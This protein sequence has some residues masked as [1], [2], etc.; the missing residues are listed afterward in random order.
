MRY[1]LDTAHGKA[2]LLDRRRVIAY[3]LDIADAEKMVEALN[4]CDVFS[5]YDKI[6]LVPRYP[7]ETDVPGSH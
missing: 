5:K 4:Q 6:R 1:K 2:T 7:E 3:G